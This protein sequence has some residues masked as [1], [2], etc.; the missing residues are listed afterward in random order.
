M[1]RAGSSDDRA[2]PAALPV[3]TQQCDHGHSALKSSGTSPNFFRTTAS[4]NSLTFG[5]PARLSVAMALAG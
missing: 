4:E 3:I 1:S 5:S 2:N